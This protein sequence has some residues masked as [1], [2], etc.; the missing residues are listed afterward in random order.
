MEIKSN[1]I[2]KI[3]VFEHIK[4]ADEIK[5]MIA[6]KFKCENLINKGLFSDVYH[7]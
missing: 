2:E 1:L 3:N 7:C 6:I 5:K 4:I